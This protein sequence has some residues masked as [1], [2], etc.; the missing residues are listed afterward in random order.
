MRTCTVQIVSRSAG[1]LAAGALVPAQQQC[2][3]AHHGDTPQTKYNTLSI[4]HHMEAPRQQ[5]VVTGTKIV[6]MQE[7]VEIAYV[8]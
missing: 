3:G 5:G 6:S 2:I 1:P 7:C 8:F 4:K